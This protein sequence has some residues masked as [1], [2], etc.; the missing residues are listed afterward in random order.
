MAALNNRNRQLK[1]KGSALYVKSKRLT[2][3]RHAHL[4][5]GRFFWSV[6]KSF[7]T[8]TR[9]RRMPRTMMI[10]RMMLWRASEDSGMFC[11]V[12]W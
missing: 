10:P 12:K 2:N 3:D 11:G 8:I 1:C 7:E 9:P 5:P 4:K 6:Q